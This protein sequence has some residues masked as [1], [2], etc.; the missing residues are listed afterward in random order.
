MEKGV[1]PAR[2]MFKGACAHARGETHLAGD[3]SLG[4]KRLGMRGKA[5]AARAYH[6]GVQGGASAR[7]ALAKA[8]WQRAQLRK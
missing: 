4:A 2:C 5:A 7:H 3:L 1:K 6:G 8:F